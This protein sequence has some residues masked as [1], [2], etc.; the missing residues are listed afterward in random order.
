MAETMEFGA[1]AGEHV[2][3]IGGG[4]G[5]DLAQFAAHG[6]TVTDLDLS[7]GHLDLAKENFTLRGLTGRFVLHDAETL[8]FP[9]GSFDLVY[10]NGVLHHTP[11]TREVVEE[12]RRVLRPGGR[13]IVMMYAENSWHYFKLAWNL[14]LEK[15]RLK[16]LSIGD[17]MSRY[18]E[19]TRNDAR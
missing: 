6:A 17:I 16:K 12:I 14:G 2:L 13:A 18:V 3:E 1:H 7:A 11:N 4:M 10:S 15:E 5:T 9:D 8:P 19:I